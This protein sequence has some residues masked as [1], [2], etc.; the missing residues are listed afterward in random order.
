MNSLQNVAVL[1]RAWN[2]NP[3]VLERT[4]DW[5][6]MP[7]GKLV[8]VVNDTFDPGVITGQ[9]AQITDDRLE[10]V[11]ITENFSACR[12]LN[13]GVQKVREDEKITQ[14]LCASVEALLT[15]DHV[16]QMQSALT[17]N[18]VVG[19]TFT[20]VLENN[21]PFQL[22][23]SYFKHPLNTGALY[24]LAKF[25]NGPEFDVWCDDYE[26]AYG[27]E[28][29]D[30]ILREKLQYEFLDLQVP[31]VIGRFYDQ[32]DKEHRRENAVKYVVAR[33]KAETDSPEWLEKTLTKMNLNES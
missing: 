7:I 13:A 22:P 12:A 25:E 9:L 23:P 11:S 5:L 28:D 33:A 21:E 3:A 27:M 6:E 10:V 2:N 20:G 14:V 4:K 30:I 24:D 8:I 26:G 31:L 17:D 15:Q 19:T 32:E 1:M 18:A 29:L 16:T